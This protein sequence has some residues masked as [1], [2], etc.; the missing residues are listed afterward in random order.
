M[1]E[2]PLGYTEHN[3]ESDVELFSSFTVFFFGVIIYETN[4][5]MQVILRTELSSSIVV[6][7]RFIAPM[8]QAM[9]GISKMDQD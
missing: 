1:F 4:K 2:I 3:T 7:G 8:Y 6:L 5:R 9:E